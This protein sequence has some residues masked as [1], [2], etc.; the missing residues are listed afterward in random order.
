MGDAAEVW[1]PLLAPATAL[2]HLAPETLF[3]L[4][5]PGDIGE[6][7]EFLWRQADER[8]VDLITSGE[9]TKDWPPTLLPPREWK[10]RLLGARTLELTWESEAGNAI[11]GGGKSSGDLFGWREPQLPPG[12]GTRIAD[13]VERWRGDDGEDG[14]RTKPRIVIASDQALRL[15]EILEEA[16]TPAGVTGAIQEPPPAGAVALIDRSLNG[17]FAGG[18]DGLVFVTDRELFGNVR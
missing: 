12:R 16:G 1:A 10:R 8:R 11:A 6:A 2:D 4:D 17:G 3:V 7:A 15:A 9:L 18:P 5:E 14:G 13:A